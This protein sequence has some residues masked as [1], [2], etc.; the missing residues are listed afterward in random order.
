[1]AISDL[2]LDLKGGITTTRMGCVRVSEHLERRSDELLD[3]V[4]PGPTDHGQSNSIDNDAAAVLVEQTKTNK[5]YKEIR[6][7]S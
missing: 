6:F 7:S 2:D 1:M 3:K 5:E 4:N